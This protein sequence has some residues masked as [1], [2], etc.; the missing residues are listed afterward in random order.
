MAK[1]RGKKGAIGAAGLLIFGLVTPGLLM[2]SFAPVLNEGQKEVH[3]I[4]CHALE[5]VE[6]MILAKADAGSTSVEDASEGSVCGSNGFSLAQAMCQDMIDADVC[7]F[8]ELEKKVCGA[9]TLCSAVSGWFSDVLTSTKTW[10]TD[11]VKGAGAYLVKTAKLAVGA[12]VDDQEAAEQDAA[13]DGDVG[14]A[15]SDAAASTEGA[16]ADAEIVQAEGGG[17]PATEPGDAGVPGLEAVESLDDLRAGGADCVDSGCTTGELDGSTAD[18]PSLR[19]PQV[20]ADVGEAVE[21]AASGGGVLAKLAAGVKVVAKVLGVGLK[22][23]GWVGIGVIALKLLSELF[24]GYQVSAQDLEGGLSDYSP[25]DLWFPTGQS[26]AA[27]DAEWASVLADPASEAN[28]DFVMDMTTDAGEGTVDGYP[29]W[30]GVDEEPSADDWVMTSVFNAATGG[31][32]QPSGGMSVPFA[33]T[34]TVELWYIYEAAVNG[35][36]PGGNNCTG[37]KAPATAAEQAAIKAAYISDLDLAGYDGTAVLAGAS[38][39]PA[40]CSVGGTIEG[41]AYGTSYAHWATV[42]DLLGYVAAP[43][44]GLGSAWATVLSEVE[45]PGSTTAGAA[46]DPCPGVPAARQQLLGDLKE[47]NDGPYNELLDEAEQVVKTGGGNIDDYPAEVVAALQ[48][49]PTGAGASATAS[50][51]LVVTPATPMTQDEGE[52]IVL[53]LADVLGGGDPTQVATSYVE[54]QNGCSAS[55]CITGTG[56]NIGATGL[57]ASQMVDGYAQYSRGQGTLDPGNAQDQYE[58]AAGEMAQ[59]LN[60]NGGDL[61]S[62]FAEYVQQNHLPPYAGAWAGGYSTNPSAAPTDPS[63]SSESCAP[64]QAAELDAENWGCEV[65]AYS[66]A[67]PEMPTAVL[68][69]EVTGEYQLYLDYTD[70][71]ETDTEIAPPAYLLQGQPMPSADLMALFDAAATE[72]NA[73]E[74][75]LLAIAAQE[76]GFATQACENGIAGA[77]GNFGVMGMAGGAFVGKWPPKPPP[78]GGEEVTVGGQ[79]YGPTA[80]VTGSAGT[81]PTVEPALAGEP[82]GMLDPA[83]EIDLAAYVLNGWGATSSASAAQLTTATQDYVLE[84]VDGA[85]STTPVVAAPSAVVS[86]VDVRYPAYANWL[87]GG[88]PTGGPTGYT[89]PPPAGFTCCVVQEPLQSVFAWV[90]PTGYPDSFPFGQ[91]TYWADYNVQTISMYGING[92]AAQWPGSPGGQ[93]AAAA[94]LVEMDPEAQPMVDPPP[95][96]GAVVWNPTPEY[97][98]QGQLSGWL[99]DQGTGHVG[100]VVSVDTN[101]AGTVTGYWVSEMNFLGEGEVDE[102]WVQWPDPDVLAFILPPPGTATL[103]G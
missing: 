84:M 37:S 99:Y 76:S 91:C 69:A 44:Y 85:G 53:A 90:P 40:Q 17:V 22:V 31:L 66:N 65:G 96:G 2:G 59:Y 34:P 7:T 98:A 25:G 94:H 36:R 68:L 3:K 18:D 29:V 79:T 27:R 35:G 62:A 46:A 28:F 9:V 95:I 5:M 89:G 75:L 72:Y 26:C 39:A 15:A 47:G 93:R 48:A 33:P 54:D 41:Q 83:D 13:L 10:L 56:G 23:L 102:R 55:S 103:G 67:D 52:A 57:L 38:T 87:S 24:Q 11:Q 6:K 20:L 74:P 92:N 71:D 97:N 100:V 80:A 12:S 61:T 73:S 70:L 86:I 42:Q 43:Q 63:D 4:E 51:D 49:L 30:Y 1:G 32:V 60:E 88:A 50:P 81:C 77:G 45:A 64:D 21:T 82:A 14:A 19:D 8:S 78:S 16:E 101:A 58:A